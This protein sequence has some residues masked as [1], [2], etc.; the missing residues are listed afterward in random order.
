MFAKILALGAVSVLAGCAYQPE[1]ITGAMPPLQL[2]D[3]SVQQTTMAAVYDKNCVGPTVVMLITY[4]APRG[5]NT[6]RP[7]ASGTVSGDGQCVELLAAAGKIIGYSILA[8]KDTNVQSV[9]V[10]SAT[11]VSTATASGG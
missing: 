5:S 3:G 2:A 8:G 6:L 1:D 4:H 7:V 10:S 9:A 11:A